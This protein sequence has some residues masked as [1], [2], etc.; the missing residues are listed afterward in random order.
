[1]GPWDTVLQKVFMNFLCGITLR[2]I[3]RCAYP[4]GVLNTA[5]YI[6]VKI[7]SAAHF[8]VVPRGAHTWR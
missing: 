4:D 1:M 2:S 5:D 6:T 3:F 8:D 7:G